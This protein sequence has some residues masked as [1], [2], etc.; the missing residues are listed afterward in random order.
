MYQPGDHVVHP[1]HGAGVITQVIRQRVDGQEKS[2]FALQLQT[3]NV[4]ILIPV[5]GCASVGV[6]P[7]VTCARAEEVLDAFRVLDTGSDAS[8]NRRYRENMLRLRSGRLDEV[9]R[10]VKSLMLR[11]REHGLSA[12]ERRMLSTA[13]QILLSE[14]SI[15]TG[16]SVEALEKTLAQLLE[17]G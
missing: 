11:E 16:Q 10:V 7:V 5:D 13:R 15:A 8:W 12:G 6:R 1:L 14:L 9:S 17:N 4:R 2:Y 3:E